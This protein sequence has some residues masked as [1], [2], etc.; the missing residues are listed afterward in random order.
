MLRLCK[1]L[2]EEKEVKEDEWEIEEVEEEI[3]I[4]PKEEEEEILTFAT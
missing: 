2:N 1:H 3:E 4:T